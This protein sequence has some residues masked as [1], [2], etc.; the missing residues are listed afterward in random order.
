MKLSLIL[1]S[2]M[3]NFLILPEIMR[4]AGWSVVVGI[5]LAVAF[6][7]L[8]LFLIR[9][10]YPKSTFSPLSMVTAVLLG[11]LLCLEFIP[12]CASV[13]LKWRLDDFELW[14][15]ENVV[16]PELFKIPEEVTTEESKEIIKK[17]VDEYPILGVIVGSGEFTG[18]D[19]SNIA[20]AMKDELNSFLNR[21]I[22]KLLLIALVETAFCAFVIIKTQSR[23]M[24]NRRETRNVGNG[25]HTSTLG[26]RRTS[27]PG[28]GRRR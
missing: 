26:S 9:G 21:I 27:R 22:I 5:L 11:L 24:Q 7:G 18:F 6:V 20:S 1:S 3:D 2:L 23:I 4:H 19:T 14:I 25:S 17:A 12:L 8:L 28:G 16:H 15:N 13:A 10:F